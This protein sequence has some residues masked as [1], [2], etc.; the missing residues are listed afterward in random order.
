MQYGGAGDTACTTV[1]NGQFYEIPDKKLETIPSFRD[2]RLALAAFKDFIQVQQLAEDQINNTSARDAARMQQQECPWDAPGTTTAVT[3]GTG[4]LEGLWCASFKRLK[5]SLL[6]LLSFLLCV[7]ESCFPRG[8]VSAAGRQRAKLCTKEPST[9]CNAMFKVLRAGTKR[10][11]HF[12]QDKEKTELVQI[13]S[14]V[15]LAKQ[16]QFPQLLLIGLVLQTLHQLRCPSLDMLQ[17]LNVFLVVKGPKLNTV[18]MM[19]PHQ[20]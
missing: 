8:E 1:G 2:S 11:S 15:P 7:Q 13:L 18:F 17:P 5:R 20:C 12:Q 16:P 14:P 6:L 4:G 3:C 10:G 9:Q 19:Q